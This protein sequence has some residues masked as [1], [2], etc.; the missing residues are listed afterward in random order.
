LS[1]SDCEDPP[2]TV[3]NGPVDGTSQKIIGL[4]PQ[5]KCVGASCGRYVWT[6]WPVYEDPAHPGTP[7]LRQPQVWVPNYSYTSGPS[8]PVI[9][10][11]S[12]SQLKANTGTAGST[13]LS[14]TGF[15]D[16]PITGHLHFDYIPDNQAKIDVNSSDIALGDY[17]SPKSKLVFADSYDCDVNFTITPHPS[18]TYQIA[19]NT[20]NSDNVPTG[21]P[22]TVIGTPIEDDSTHLHTVTMT[23]GTA[24][25]GHRDESCCPD[26][27]PC[28]DPR[29]QCNNY[30]DSSPGATPHCR[31]CGGAGNGCCASGAQCDPGV[32]PF[33]PPGP[34]CGCFGCGM[35]GIKCC[36]GDACDVGTCQNHTCKDTDPPP[37]P[38]SCQPGTCNTSALKTPQF[39]TGLTKYLQSS[40][41]QA[42]SISLAPGLDVGVCSISQELLQQIVDEGLVQCEPSLA[43]GWTDPSP[44]GT[45]KEYEVYV[46][47]FPGLAPVQ[48]SS[49]PGATFYGDSSV[50]AA[51][52]TRRL[53]NVVVRA[54]DCCGDHS[55]AAVGLFAVSDSCPAPNY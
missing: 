26:G 52:G 20:W 46:R 40:C 2:Q 11:D 27:V 14:L 9:F 48:V 21:Q 51:P 50:K 23:L 32:F 13:V 6:V 29:T 17:C 34:A 18:Q 38:P 28:T 36:N 47:E 8:K 15:S 12:P 33:G 24:S 43:F 42:G 37:P 39:G 4:D 25:C 41:V 22:G 30:T 5:G 3:F 35:P 55:Q 7:W 54:N 1:G 53:F 19:A 44:P 31:T 10:V 49:F 16:T 45:A